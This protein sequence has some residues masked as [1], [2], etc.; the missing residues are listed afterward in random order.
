MNF[1]T[2]KKT[3]LSSGFCVRRYEIPEWKE[4]IQ[5]LWI[6]AMWKVF[7]YHR[8]SIGNPEFSMIFRKWVWVTQW[9]VRSIPGISSYNQDFFPKPEMGFDTQEKTELSSGFYVS[10]HGEPEEKE[11]NSR[12]RESEKEWNSR[13]RESLQREKDSD[14]MGNSGF[15]MNWD[16]E[17]TELSSGF[18]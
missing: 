11:W 4:S 10:S 12:S 14:L 3:E 13:S 15:S 9:H 7:R 16:R 2:Q 18:S 1:D 5:G 17:K 6:T 8:G